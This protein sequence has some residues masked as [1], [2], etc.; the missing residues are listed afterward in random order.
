MVAMVNC[1]VCSGCHGELSGMYWLSWSM[2]RYVMVAKM[3]SELKRF[4]RSL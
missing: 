3:N 4:G 2:V 1:L